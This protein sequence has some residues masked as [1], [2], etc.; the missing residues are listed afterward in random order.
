MK[1]HKIDNT[2]S[3][4]FE[5]SIP[6]L[7]IF[8][9]A[10]FESIDD[11]PLNV[12]LKLFIKSELDIIKHVAAEKSKEKPSNDDSKSSILQFVLN[13]LLIKYGG[14]ESSIVT[15]SEHSSP[16]EGVKST[17]T[18]QN[19]GKVTSEFR[20]FMDLPIELHDQVISEW[21]I[22]DFGTLADVAESERCLNI[23]IYAREWLTRRLDKMKMF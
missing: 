12:F 22:D 5:Y 16:L 17:Q 7:Q 14:N 2:N 13:K 21:N 19:Q 4:I 18:S 11:I 23:A 9:T 6:Y 15:E 1:K 10:K 20:S 8:P 3:F